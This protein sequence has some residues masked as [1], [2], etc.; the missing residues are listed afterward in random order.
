MNFRLE[1]E[2]LYLREITAD[3]AQLA[4]EL[5]LDE[6]VIRYTGDG[7]FES[8][9]EARD[10]LSKYDHYQKYGFGR[11]GVIRKSDNEFLG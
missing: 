2:R 8:V 11:W 1:T 6:E 5:N 4:Y 7:P 9:E 10:F 3:D